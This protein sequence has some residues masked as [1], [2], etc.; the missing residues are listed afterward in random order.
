MRSLQTR[1]LILNVMPRPRRRPAPRKPFLG[2]PSIRAGLALFVLSAVGALWL[3]ADWWICLPEGEA[4]SATYEGGEACGQCHEKELQSWTGSDHDRAMDLATPATVL[5]DGGQ[6][7]Q[8]LLNLLLNAVEAS[9]DGGRLTLV[10]RSATLDGTPAAA[11]EV[12]DEGP[13]MDDDTRRRIFDPFFSTK[14]AGAGLGLSVVHQIVTEHS[15][16]VEVDT[17]VGKGARFRVILP[18]MAASMPAPLTAA[19]A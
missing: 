11:F 4:E 3:A 6:I 14:P 18:G 1:R 2:R 9:P 10:V 15:G 13:G 12:A 17:A 7:R 16:R 8:V 5:A 19:E